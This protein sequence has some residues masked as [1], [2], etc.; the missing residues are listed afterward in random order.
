MAGLQQE[1]PRLQEAATIREAGATT[2]PNGAQ[3]HYLP[4]EAA[5]ATAEAADGDDD[6][7][8]NDDYY[9]EEGGEEEESGGEEAGRRHRHRSDPEGKGCRGC[10]AGPILLGSGTEGG[11]APGAIDAAR[12]AAIRANW[13]ASGNSGPSSKRRSGRCFDNASTT[14]AAAFPATATGPPGSNAAIACGNNAA[15]ALC[16]VKSGANSWT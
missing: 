12:P 14:M 11:G 16:C 7:D 13:A 4:S 5:A 6:W 10:P 15:G 3:H 8:P 2:L 1:V 9:W